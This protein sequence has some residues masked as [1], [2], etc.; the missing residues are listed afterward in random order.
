[1]SNTD[2][3]NDLINHQNCSRYELLTYVLSRNYLD[4]Y[5]RFYKIIWD[6]RADKYFRINEK[7]S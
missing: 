3:I 6:A 2:I 4:V 5:Q 1:M 7:N